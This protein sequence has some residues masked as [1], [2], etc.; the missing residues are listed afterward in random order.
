MAP[1]LFSL[2]HQEQL[3]ASS[4]G[5]EARKDVPRIAVSRPSAGGEPPFAT[6][7]ASTTPGWHPCDKWDNAGQKASDERMINSGC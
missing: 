2:L 3:A 4:S 5:E 1:L 7:C 6:Y